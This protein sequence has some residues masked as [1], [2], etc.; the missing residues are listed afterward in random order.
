MKKF[1]P[2]IALLCLLTSCNSYP[3]IPQNI[4][5]FVGDFS[6]QESYDRF[7]AGSFV[8]Q[9]SLIDE[10]NV[11]LGAHT[12]DFKFMRQDKD[13]YTFRA[14]YNYRGEEVKDGINERVKELRYDQEK[15]TQ[16][17]DVKENAETQSKEI[18]KSDAEK[19]F[20]YTF[21]TSWQAYPV[22]GLYYGDYLINQLTKI[23]TNVVIDEKECTFTFS[24][25]DSVSVEDTIVSQVFKVNKYGMLLYSMSRIENKASKQIGTLTQNIVYEE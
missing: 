14:Q 2:S 1:V 10:N 24:Y 16:Y 5:D 15:S 8:E 19:Y 23:Y 20:N 9:Y 18:S 25:V 3:D 7:H 17:Y 4:L 6:Y 12:I 21:Y 11:E 22:G 13:Y